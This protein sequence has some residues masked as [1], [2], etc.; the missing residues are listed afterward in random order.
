MMH[1]TLFLVA[2]FHNMLIPGLLY[3]MIAGYQYWFPKAFG[4]RLDERWG[5]FTFICWVAGFYLAFMPLYVLGAMGMARRTQEVFTPAFLPWLIVAGTGALVLLAALCGLFVQLWVSI[6]D[7][8]ANRVFIGDPWAGRSLEWSISSP[9]PAYNFALRPQVES[10][11]DFTRRKNEGQAVRYPHRYDDIEIPLNSATGPVIGIAGAL[12]GFAMVWHIWWL[13]IG[14]FL[15]IWGAVIARS[16]VRKV[17][18]TIPARLIARTEQRWLNAV[19]AAPP[20]EREE[21]TSHANTGRSQ[22]DRR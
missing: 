15:A 4:F 2:H 19:A 5:R 3:G 11:D 8:E 6:R 12:C 14:G 1:N 20:A 7:R 10:R 17:H 18:R 13:A 21:E 22:E 16:F 9:P